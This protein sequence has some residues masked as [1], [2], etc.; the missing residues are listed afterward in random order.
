MIS[1]IR[2]LLVEDC[3]DILFIMKTE[4]EWMG[5]SVL[6]AKDARTALNIVKTTLPDVIVS[7]IQMPGMD[8]FEFIRRV[9]SNP[10]LAGIPAIALSGF[11]ME[12]NVKEALDHGFSAHRTKPVEPS[13][14]NDLIQE[15]VS[16]PKRRLAGA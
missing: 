16:P 6:L 13:D 5:Y 4:L 3:E 2:I 11:G 1:N 15:L 12:K 10:A 9:R 7:D 8:G 14:L